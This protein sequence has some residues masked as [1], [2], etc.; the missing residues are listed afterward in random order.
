MLFRSD[1]HPIRRTTIN[2]DVRL[3][4]PTADG[5]SPLFHKPALLPPMVAA[6][7]EKET[8]AFR[9]QNRLYAE[10]YR[11]WGGRVDELV[12]P[13]VHHFDIILEFLKP[14]SALCRALFALMGLRAP[15]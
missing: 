13:G 12:L 3:D 7:G 11:L 14:E 15:S 10:A 1:L 4:Q 5:A 6:V 2:D 8:Y 9:E